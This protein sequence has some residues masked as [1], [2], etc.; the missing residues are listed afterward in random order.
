M[1]GYV[2]VVKLL[3]EHNACVA[4]ANKVGATPL[5]SAL[6][7]GHIDVAKI[8]IDAGATID[9]QDL[10]GVT[11]VQSVCELEHVKLFRRKVNEM[12]CSN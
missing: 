7:C 6:Q 3:I 9:F 2:R 11:A 12:S 8:L 10:I 4:L 5:R 1:E